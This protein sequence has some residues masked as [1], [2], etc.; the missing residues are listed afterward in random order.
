MQSAHESAK[1]KSCR[2][3]KSVD[4]DVSDDEIRAPPTSSA[5]KSASARSR[6]GRPVAGVTSSRTTLAITMSTRI[7]ADIITASAGSSWDDQLVDCPHAAHERAA[8]S[9][10]VAKPHLRIAEAVAS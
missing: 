5:T 10:S 3:T 6:F 1:P 8:K 7:V 9:A 4:S 2:P